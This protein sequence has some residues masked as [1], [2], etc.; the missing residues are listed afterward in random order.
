[1]RGRSVIPGGMTND[2]D[3]Q[4]HRSGSSVKRRSP[5]RWRA[6]GNAFSIRDWFHW[7]AALPMMG[8]TRRTFVQAVAMGAAMPAMAADKVGNPQRQTSGVR[9]R[10]AR[11]ALEALGARCIVDPETER[12][13][14]IS[15]NDN[16]RV[17]DEDLRHAAHFSRLTDLS[18]EG[19]K[20]G[21]A[22]MKH[23]TE[24]KRL[25]WLN[26]YRTQVGDEGVGHLS[27]IES[28]QHL[29]IGRTR[30]T[31][32]GLKAVGRMKR[33]VYL[34]LRGNA[35]TDVGLANLKDLQNLTGLHLGETGVT[36]TGLRHLRGLNKLQKLW[37]HDTRVTDA[38]VAE[39]KKLP[40]LQQLVIYNTKFSEKGYR[41]LSAA[42]SG[43]LIL[44][45][46]E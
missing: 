31:D 25:E 41:E 30:V 3:R 19:T 13:T 27:R 17:R 4:R 46:A 39:L 29:P 24:L 28:L 10:H 45:R 12:V 14:E 26:L 42:R 22:G 21:D 43:M 36:D 8:M 35:V 34:G 18:L 37:L 23:L 6:D 38:A 40:K 11:R 44:Y 2:G 9:R 32:A 20:I 5:R 16:A 33:L 15:L 1:M 7:E